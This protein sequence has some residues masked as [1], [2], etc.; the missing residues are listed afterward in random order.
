MHAFF[1]SLCSAHVF[2]LIPT[3]GSAERVI[4]DGVKGGDNATIIV[5]GYNLVQKYQK[6]SLVATGCFGGVANQNFDDQC[7]VFECDKSK[8]L[9]IVLMSTLIPLGTL[10]LVYGGYVLYRKRQN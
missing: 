10:A 7:S 2:Q 3:V 5:T 4:I 6:Y 8:T 1:A 9:Q